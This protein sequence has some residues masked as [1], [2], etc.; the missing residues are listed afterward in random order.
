MDPWIAIQSQSV[1]RAGPLWASPFCPKDFL[2]R[3]GRPPRGDSLRREMSRD[4]YGRQETLS[5]TL[6][7]MARLSKRGCQ[8]GNST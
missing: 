5:R 2:A 1:L 8:G 3:P 7:M 6:L 4:A